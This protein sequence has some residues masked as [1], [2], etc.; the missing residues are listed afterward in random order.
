MFDT[1]T[2]REV[3]QEY[4]ERKAATAHGAYVWDYCVRLAE[5]AEELGCGVAPDELTIAQCAA[6]TA[7][8]AK[9]GGRC[10]R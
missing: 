5:I 4:E 8:V 9:H 3:W 2:P 10:D 7:A 1:I 6:Q